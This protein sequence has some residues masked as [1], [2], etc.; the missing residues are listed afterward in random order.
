MKSTYLTLLALTVVTPAFAA[1]PNAYILT[2]L[3]AS[4]DTYKPLHID[5][6]LINAWGIA[7]RPAGLGGHFW[8]AANGT[9][10]SSQW[11]GDVG[12]TPLYQDDLRIVSVPGPISNSGA[13]PSQPVVLPGTPTGV[14]FNGSNNFVIKQGSITAPSK[15]LFATDNG[16]LSGW[17]ERKNS[18][19][20]FD[21][22]FNAVTVVDR[23][24]DESVFRLGRRRSRWSPLHRQLR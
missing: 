17:T 16:T 10:I 8:I 21:R 18:D 9:G 22:P 23:S 13:T 11:V 15:F 6:T 24:A 7:I 2:N 5:P 3:I 12:K 4:S 19:G 1:T 20:S 14:A